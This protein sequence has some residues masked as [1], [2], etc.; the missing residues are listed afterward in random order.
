MLIYI[1]SISTDSS[2]TTYAAGHTRYVAAGR[3]L[4]QF[5]SLSPLI[6]SSVVQDGIAPPG[7]SE[8]QSTQTDIQKD[9]QTQAP[10]EIGQL[11]LVDHSDM[12]SHFPV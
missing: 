3:T 10:A 8:R 4:P 12:V 9:R 11:N 6:F 7:Q 5:P 2:L 1:I